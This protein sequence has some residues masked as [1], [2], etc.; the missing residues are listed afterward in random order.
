MAQ[1]STGGQSSPPECVALEPSLEVAIEQGETVAFRVYCQDVD[2]D[3]AGGAW[4]LNGEVVQ[5]VTTIHPDAFV[6]EAEVPIQI[7]F[8][9]EGVNTVA[10][11]GY[12]AMDSLSPAVVWSVDAQ[13]PLR[14]GTAPSCGRVAPSDPVTARRDEH[15]TFEAQCTDADGDI[16]SVEWYLN[17]VWTFTSSPT[18]PTRTNAQASIHLPDLARHEVKAIAFDSSG[19]QSAPATWNVDVVS[20]PG[21]PAQPQGAAP[22]EATSSGGGSARVTAFGVIAGGIAALVTAFV[23]IAKLRSHKGGSDD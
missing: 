9:Q 22:S 5:E 15:P 18:S 4:G 8:P 14:L 17:D 13:I 1:T 10:F 2:G 6:Y 21:A 11:V 16:L 3:L 19:L 12:D 23:A 7:S 20:A